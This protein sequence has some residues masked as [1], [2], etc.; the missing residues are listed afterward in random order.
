M[1]SNGVTGDNSACD[2]RTFCPVLPMC[3]VV[4][5]T[6]APALAASKHTLDARRCRRHNQAA[7]DL[8]YRTKPLP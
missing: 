2:D 1:P 8:T 6:I 4:N 3:G 7:S 5:K